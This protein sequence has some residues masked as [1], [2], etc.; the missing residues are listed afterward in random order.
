MTSPEHA[1]VPEARLV[2]AN[3]AGELAHIS[4]QL[5]HR[6]IW[7]TQLDLR[8]IREGIAKL[9]EAEQ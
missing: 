2:L 1:P 9:L 6:A 4:G 3:I 7:E 5:A 8:R